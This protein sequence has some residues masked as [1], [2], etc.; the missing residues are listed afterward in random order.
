M[1][2][3][4]AVQMNPLKSRESPK[5]VRTPT[6]TGAEN[7]GYEPPP[8]VKINNRSAYNS[9]ESTLPP[10]DESEGVELNIEDLPK[11]CFCFY[12]INSPKIK[13]ERVLV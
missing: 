13:A 11:V 4:E 3:L 2:D 10:I 7:E 5:K 12:Y 6:T 9:R 1:D 8:D